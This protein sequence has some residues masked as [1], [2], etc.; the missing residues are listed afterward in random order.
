LD[1][2]DKYFGQSTRRYY[3]RDVAERRECLDH[4]H[5]R[6]D[7]VV[8]PPDFPSRESMKMRISEYEGLPMLGAG[9]STIFERRLSVSRG[10]EG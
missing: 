3:Y 10:N 6:F 2:R 4:S 9:R 8:T 1:R 5:L 7:S